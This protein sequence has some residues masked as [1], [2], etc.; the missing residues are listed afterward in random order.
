MYHRVLIHTKDMH[1]HRFLWRNLEADQPPDTYVMNVLTFGDKPAPA[2]AKVA[3]KK[4]AENGKQISQEAAQTIKVNTYMDDILGSVGAT[5]EAKKLTSDIDQILEN[6]GFEVK[7]WRSNKE[8]NRNTKTNET[9]LPLSQTEAKVLGVSWNCKD[10]I[11][12]YKFEIDAVKSSS[13]ELTKRKILSQIAR[14]YDPIGFTAPF[15]VKAKINLQQLWEEGFDWDDKLP[16][17]LQKKWLSYFTEMKQLNGVSFERC[18][19]PGDVLEPSILCIFADASQDAF[20]TCAYLRSKNASGEIRVKFVAAKCRVAPLKELTIPK[21][22]LASRLCKS[23]QNEICLQLQESIVF[24]DSATALAWIRN[25]SKRLKPFVASRVEEIRNNVRPAQWKHILSEQNVADD[26]SQ[27]LSVA[28]L[29]VSWLNG[30]EFL[31]QPEEEWPTEKVQL[32]PTEVE[33]EYKKVKAAVGVVT[34]QNPG[35]SNIIDYQ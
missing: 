23:I 25:N 11:L 17:N 28:D 6:G 4:I 29:P 35:L 19:C 31:H 9:K 15:L 20:G 26:V 14:I 2:M 30:P 18:I 32:D 13:T 8:L 3:L 5:K 16:G 34:S 10:D 22:E 33:R 12:K 24:T 27:C 21:L 7:G 1:V